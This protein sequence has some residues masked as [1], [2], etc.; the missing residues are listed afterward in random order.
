[1]KKNK[2]RLIQYAVTIVV[3]IILLCG[4]FSIIKRLTGTSSTDKLSSNV[5][6]E[7]G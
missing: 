2:M 3:V 6:K 4:I 5:S 1:M 7:Q